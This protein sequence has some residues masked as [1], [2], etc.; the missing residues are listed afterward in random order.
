MRGKLLRVLPLA[1]ALVSMGAS[2]LLV[3]CGSGG[4]RFRYVQASTGAAGAVDVDVNGKAILTGIGYGLQGTY[5]KT[6][7]GS[8][9]I[10]IF[11]TGTTTNPYF[12]GSVSLGSGD[13]TLISE[14]PF[15]SITLAAYTDDNALPASG[16]VKLRFINAGP[17][18]GAVDV[19]VITPPGGGIGGLNPQI[20]NL[21]YPNASAYLSVSAG[22]YEV[23]MTQHGTQNPVFQLDDTYTFTAG[24]VR[25]ILVLDAATGGGPY[26]QLVLNDLN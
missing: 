12:K 26:T 22:N 20:N 6:S 24:Q 2:L 9:T 19:Y 13:T 17:S 18:A 10:E 15:S 16:N 4:A 14:N 21:A 11:P 23:V 1:A 5:Q 8:R 25:T 7:S 3:G